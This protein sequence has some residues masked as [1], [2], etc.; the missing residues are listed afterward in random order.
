[1]GAP[2]ATAERDLAQRLHDDPVE[3]AR[4]VLGVTCWSRQREFLR[5]VANNS[6]TATR[7][8]HKVSKSTSLAILALWWAMTR[9]RAIVVMSATAGHQI[10][11][12][13]WPELVRLYEG[14]PAPL[15]GSLS[16]DYH[17]GLSFSGGRRIFGKKVEDSTPEAFAGISSP[18]LMYVIDE[19]SGFPDALYE[20]ARGNL[21]GGGKLVATSNPTRIGGWYYDA[22]HGSRAAW[23]TLHI[24]S[25][26]SPNI[27][28]LEPAVPGLATA[29]WAADMARDFGEGSPAF[30]VRVGGA[31]PRAGDCTVNGLELVEAAQAREVPDDGELRF[32]L[33]VG[34][35]GDDP[36]VLCMVRGKRAFRFEEMRGA[37]GDVVAGWVLNL[38]R[39]VRR[40]GDER[41]LVR[42]DLI[43]VGTS[44]YD[45]LKHSAEVRAVGVNVA[46]SPNDDT[47]YVRRRD[48][49][50]FAGRSFLADGAIAN[51]GELHGELT[52]ARYSFDPRGRYLVESKDELKK[53]L[54]RSSNKAD[55]FNLAV[56]DD[57]PAVLDDGMAADFAE[58]WQREE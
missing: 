43:G 40:D 42:I 49:L 17:R 34:R 29:Q 20:A 51:D 53:R 6:R 8:G 7:S 31:F 30:A 41:P 13:L 10:T 21:A 57:A 46:T 25:R 50:W 45:T 4:V 32:G 44:V 39:E 48:E 47:R 18:N 5:A 27:T 36:S 54:K 16:R 58:V 23:A 22:F 3:F 2:A 55:A 9:P 56:S 38:V 12:T 19:A 37:E 33:D 15:G 35:T 14:A 24:D 11:D 52:A 1:M 28:G 26:E